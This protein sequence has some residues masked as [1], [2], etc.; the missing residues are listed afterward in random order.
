[1]CVNEYYATVRFGTHDALARKEHESRKKENLHNRIEPRKQAVN[2]FLTTS[3]HEAE[4]PAKKEPAKR[5][6]EGRETKRS[7]WQNEYGME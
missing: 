2:L 4:C 6:R 5:S 7:F 3:Q 1:M